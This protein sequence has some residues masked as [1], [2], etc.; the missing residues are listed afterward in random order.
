MPTVNF[1]VPREV[2]EAFDKTFARQNKS[3]VLTQLMRQAVEEKRRRRHRARV[4][5]KLLQLRKRTRPRRD[6]AIRN[7]RRRERP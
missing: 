1:S 6:S 4:I 5:E 2:K 3:A 7:A